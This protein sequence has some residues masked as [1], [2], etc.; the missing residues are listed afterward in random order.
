LDEGAAWLTPR[1]VAPTIREGERRIRHLGDIRRSFEQLDRI[2]SQYLA[3]EVQR[4]DALRAI[5]PDERTKHS[6]EEAA[7]LHRIHEMWRWL[8]LLEEA[9]TRAEREARG[10]PEPGDDP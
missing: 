1:R 5:P 7:I 9:I 6:E 10:T 3:L 4:L 2:A 8:R